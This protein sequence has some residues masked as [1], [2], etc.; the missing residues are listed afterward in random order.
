MRKDCPQR[1]GQSFKTAGMGHGFQETKG[2]WSEALE[3]FEFGLAGPPGMDRIGTL[4][5]VSPWWVFGGF[6]VSERLCLTGF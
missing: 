4:V 3:H 1:A 5:L 6:L 2:V